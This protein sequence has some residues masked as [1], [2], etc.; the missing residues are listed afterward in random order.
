MEEGQTSALNVCLFKIKIRFD[1]T[2]PLN[3]NL[4]TLSIF[5]EIIIET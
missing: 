5:N 1:N 2:I 4:K 3:G